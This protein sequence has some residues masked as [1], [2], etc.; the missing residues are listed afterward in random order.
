MMMIIILQKEFLHA[1]QVLNSSKKA[2]CAGSSEM[3]I[4]FK[5]I[6]KMYQF[7]PYGPRHATAATFAF[8]KEL[9]KITSYEDSAAIAEEKHFLKIIQFHLFN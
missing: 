7:G 1:V 4:Y 8:K 6:N 5:H 2:L 9:L 3:H